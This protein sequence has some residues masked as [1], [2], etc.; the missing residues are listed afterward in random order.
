MVN[1]WTFHI[2]AGSLCLDFA[3]TVSWRRSAAPIERLDSLS[4]LAS[5]SRQVGLIS[6]SREQLIR[7]T[8]LRHPRQSMALLREARVLREATFAV[9]AAVS[10][11]RPAP[12]G[13]LR[14]LEQWIHEAIATSRLDRVDDKYRWRNE[15]HSQLR[16]VLRSVA[17]SCEELLRSEDV[18]RL[19]QCSG[20]DCRWL[21]IDRTKNQSRR[22][23]DMAVCGNRAKAHR[24]HQRQIQRNG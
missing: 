15:A 22:W 8:A 9:F 11:G 16:D 4:D 7:R 20:R 6:R 18:A 13:A 1:R 19:G 24:H 5:W 3:N 21:W 10:E 2:G 17:L 14:R 23:C 12:N